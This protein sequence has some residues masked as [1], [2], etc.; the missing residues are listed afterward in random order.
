MAML[1]TM[2]AEHGGSLFTYCKTLNICGIIFLQ[3]I[4]N[5]IL[6]YFNFVIHDIPWLKMPVVK[7]L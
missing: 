3:F 5:D 1:A 4:E 6:A 2:A 7:K